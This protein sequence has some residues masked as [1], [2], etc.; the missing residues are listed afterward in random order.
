MIFYPPKKEDICKSTHPP[1]YRNRNFPD[2]RLE[3]CDV[4]KNCLSR[5]GSDED[6]KVLSETTS[7]IKA[8]I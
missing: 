3:I 2:F 8:H 6:S 1:F 5:I 4:I 7:R